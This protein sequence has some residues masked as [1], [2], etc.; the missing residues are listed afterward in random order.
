M[1]VAAR[2]DGDHFELRAGGVLPTLGVGFQVLG[3][4]IMVQAADIIL[5]PEGFS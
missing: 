2:V 4:V 3:D 5:R 1:N